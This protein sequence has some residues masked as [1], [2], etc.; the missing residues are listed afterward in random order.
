MY[1][2]DSGERWDGCWITNLQ[3]YGDEHKIT[4]KY[5]RGHIIQPTCMPVYWAPPGSWSLKLT[6]FLCLPPDLSLHMFAFLR[7]SCH[8]GLLSPA[9]LSPSSKFHPQI[10]STCPRNI[11]D[12]SKHN[13]STEC[14]SL[15]KLA[16]GDQR[17]SI[18]KLEIWKGWKWLLNDI[19]GFSTWKARPATEQDS[20]A[21]N[22]QMQGETHMGTSSREPQL[23]P[24][25]FL[26]WEVWGMSVCFD[27]LT[28]SPPS[29]RE[30]CLSHW[31]NRTMG[32]SRL[33]HK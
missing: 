7:E 9:F 30:L 1:T 10:P 17:K 3:E 11:S 20:Q 6:C 8:V 31:C 29:L 26:A 28:S 2:K 12:S 22:R 18:W 25:Q 4:V 33:L 19:Q 14:K 16:P 21:H 23:T 24:Q 32:S 15:S 13:S 5:K 27:Y